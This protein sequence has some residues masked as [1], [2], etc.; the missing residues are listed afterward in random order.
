MGKKRSLYKIKKQA[1]KLQ[2]CQNLNGV[3]VLLG[4]EKHQLQLHALHPQYFYFNLPKKSGGKR[5]IEAPIEPLKI[6]Q[7]KLNDYLQ[8]FYFLVKPEASFGFIINPKGNKYPRNIK[9][10]ALAHKGNDYMMN[11]DFKDFFH[12]ITKKQIFQLFNGPLF[13]FDSQSATHLTSLCTNKGRLPMGAPTSPSL[14]NFCTLEFDNEMTNWANDRQLTYTRFVDDLTF[15]SSRPFDS[16]NT[17][18][19]IQSIGTTHGFVLNPKK[20]RF[21]SKGQKKTIT[22]LVLDDP[23]SIPQEFYGELEKDLARLAHYIEVQT[24]TGILEKNRTLVEFKQQIV[25]QLNFIAQ[26]EGYNSKEYDHY[27]GS[28]ERALQPEK[29]LLYR[30]WTNFTYH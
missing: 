2:T 29:E 12:Q 18:S 26:I 15:S 9:T 14:S 20:I 23:L 30:R 19:D 6:V 25:G 16:K 11:V 13:L 3:S 10:N 1:K 7:R 5:Q 27:M 22:G 8:A 21:Y 28:Y 4:V 24:I 17:L